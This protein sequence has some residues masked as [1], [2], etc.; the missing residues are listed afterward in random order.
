MSQ[1]TG[2]NRAE[3]EHRLTH[4]NDRNVKIHSNPPCGIAAGYVEGRG[5]LIQKTWPPADS[6]ADE[7]AA[8]ITPG[9]QHA[10]V[11]APDGWSSYLVGLQ[12]EFPAGS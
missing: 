11:R 3:L 8:I 6:V 9:Q 12:Y 4:A 5:G 1:A 7:P 10:F 2:H